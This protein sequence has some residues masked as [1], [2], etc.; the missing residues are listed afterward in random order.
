MTRVE[1]KKLFAKR[2]ITKVSEMSLTANQGREEMEKKRLVWKVEGSKNEPAV[3][4]GGPVD[5]QKLVV[6]LAPMEIRTFI[7]TLGNK[8]S[9]RL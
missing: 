9:R 2:K 8:I 1:L 7:V 3:Q 5:P 4:R 6:E